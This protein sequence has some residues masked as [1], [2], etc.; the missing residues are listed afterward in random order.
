MFR[1]HLEGMRQGMAHFEQFDAGRGPRGFGNFGGFGGRHGGRDRFFKKGNL[2]FVILKM[3]E[4][5]SH[6][7]YQ[8]IKDL[9]ERFKGFYSPSPGSVY[10]ILQMLEDRDFVSISKDGNKKVYTITDEGKKFLEDNVD[11]DAFTKRLEQFKNVDFEELKAVREQMQTLFHEF[12]KAS[13]QTLQDD[14]KKAEFDV[15]I[16]ETKER[17]QQFYK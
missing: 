6:H 1:R 5:E 11:Q 12:M 10:P 8:I 16:Q 13:Q 14:K 17:L 4:E 2:Q 15:F 9:E 3:L 7:G